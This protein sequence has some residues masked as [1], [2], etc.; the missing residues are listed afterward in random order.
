M[1][2]MKVMM[3]LTS[4]FKKPDLIRYYDYLN[5]SK[6]IV[7]NS[8][9]ELKN[10]RE[11]KLSILLDDKNLD[12]LNTVEFEVNKATSS[13]NSISSKIDN[14]LNSSNLLLIRESLE[15]Y[16]ELLDD[17]IKWVEYV[18]DEIEKIINI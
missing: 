18:N 4:K 5:E 3:N 17:S 15:L 14:I 2:M 7:F 10:N 8:F 6:E 9:Y 1:L 13:I 16:A 12:I 11:L